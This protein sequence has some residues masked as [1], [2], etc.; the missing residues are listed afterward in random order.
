MVY[1]VQLT[2]DTNTFTTTFTL[3]ATISFFTLHF[4][5]KYLTITKE[6]TRNAN[7]HALKHKALVINTDPTRFQ[8]SAAK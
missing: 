2:L 4:L 6:T 7:F 3:S 1:T 5:K 8:A